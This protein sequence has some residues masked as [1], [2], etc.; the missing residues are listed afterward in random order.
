MKA[1]ASGPC[2][3]GSIPGRSSNWRNPKSEILYVVCFI[4][5]DTDATWYFWTLTITRIKHFQSLIFKS[6]TKMCYDLCYICFTKISFKKRDGS[7]SGQKRVRK[8]QHCF[9]YQL[10]LKW[11]AK[12]HSLH[13]DRVRNCL[14]LIFVQYL[15]L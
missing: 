4:F 6:I 1:F 14:V 9:I 5:E 10:I 3:S 7:G 12:H 8:T 13:T 15:F 11:T 2:G